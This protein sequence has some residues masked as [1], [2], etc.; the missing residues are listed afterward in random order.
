MPL[1]LVILS[2]L[3]HF[4]EG[5]MIKKSGAKEPNGGFIFMSLVSL[6]SMLF[7][8]LSYIITDAEKGDFTPEVIPYALLAGFLY[9]TASLF[10]YLAIG[11][12]PFAITTLIVSYSIVLISGYGIAWLGESASPLTYAAFVGIAISLFLVR[13]E[14]QATD[15]SS[16]KTEAPRLSLKWLIYVVLATLLSALFSIVIREQQIAFG[17]SVDNECMIISLGFSALL[18]LAFGIVQSRKNSLSILKST[19]PY[20]LGAGMANGA[21]NL[22]SLITNTMMAISIS[23]PTRSVVKTAITFAYSYFILKERFLPRQL[24]G[25]VI[26][27]VSTVLLNIA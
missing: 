27:V 2:A 8:L 16:E 7:F 5:V 6:A 24:F 18:L 23:S 11:C 14:P 21:T 12:G 9:C 25:V 3:T 13:T 19:A 15:E 26:G 17:G 20:A 1:F 22:L 10:N 4:G